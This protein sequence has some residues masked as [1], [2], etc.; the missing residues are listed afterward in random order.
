[1]RN[2]HEAL[3]KACEAFNKPN[4]SL[5]LIASLHADEAHACLYLNAIILVFAI[6]QDEQHFM[7]MWN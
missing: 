1:M 7:K 2:L 4:R 5:D 3:H 6:Q